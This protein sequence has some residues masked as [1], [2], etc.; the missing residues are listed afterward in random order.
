MKAARSRDSVTR[1][2]I[3]LAPDVYVNASVALGTPPENVVQR[4]L[5]RA[6]KVRVSEWVLS[7]IESMF[8]ALPEFRDE[9]IAQ[10]VATIRGLVEMVRTDD[11]PAEKWDEALVALA[12]VA[13]AKRVITDHPDLLAQRTSAGVSFVSSE[14]WLQEQPSPPPPPS[15]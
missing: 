5:T 8:R 9:A 11:F 12:K 7:R 14:A 15:P 2:D 6:K 1:V 13:G 10:Q 4:A 3:V